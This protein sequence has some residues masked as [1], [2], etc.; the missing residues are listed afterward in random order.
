M[1]RNHFPRNL[2]MH[3]VGIIQQWRAE[4]REACVEQEPEAGKR[5]DYFPRT[6]RD[7]APLLFSS[8]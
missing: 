8:E 7:R 1:A 3:R 5:E 6:M 2:G 4:E